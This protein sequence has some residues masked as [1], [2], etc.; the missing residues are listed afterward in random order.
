M[1]LRKTHQFVC[2]HPEMGVP[3]DFT[4]VAFDFNQGVSRTTARQLVE[5]RGYV[6][7]K[8]FVRKKPNVYIHKPRPRVQKIT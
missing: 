3:M 7:K 1:P 2:W 5:K 8:A 6:I 4:T